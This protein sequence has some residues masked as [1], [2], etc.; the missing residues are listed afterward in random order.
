MKEREYP[1][2]PEYETFK[3][4][5]RSLTGIDLNA[6]KYQIH[7][8]VHMLMQRWRIQSYEDYYKTI[9]ASED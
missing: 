6:Y 7:R 4:N 2:P 3:Q 1:A 8:R 5:I 9:A